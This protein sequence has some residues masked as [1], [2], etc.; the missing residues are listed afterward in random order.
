MSHNVRTQLLRTRASTRSTY[1]PTHTQTCTHKCSHIAI[2]EKHKKT[3]TIYA[4]TKMQQ[5]L[6][7]P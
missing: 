1:L 7:M 2:D 4:H 3:N 5:S 6:L